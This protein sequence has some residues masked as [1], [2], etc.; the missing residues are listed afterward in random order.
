MISITKFCL[1]DRRLRDWNRMRKQ[2]ISP[3]MTTGE[4]N[5]NA[6]DLKINEKWQTTS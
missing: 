2:R 4:T 6:E 1:Y 5:V 3:P